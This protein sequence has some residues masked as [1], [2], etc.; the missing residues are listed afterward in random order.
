MN[1]EIAVPGGSFGVF[2][3]EG[4]QAGLPEVGLEDLASFAVVDLGQLEA[5][6]ELSGREELVLL[7]LVDGQDVVSPWS[8]Q[9]HVGLGG[10]QGHGERHVLEHVHHLLRSNQRNVHNEVEHFVG[11]IV[12]VG[13][14]HGEDVASD[15]YRAHEF[16][17]MRGQ[18]Y[19]VEDAGQ[20]LG[21]D[22][23]GVESPQLGHGHSVGEDSDFFLNHGG[24]LLDFGELGSLVHGE[25]V[26][27]SLVVSEVQ[28]AVVGKDLL[29]L[30]GRGKQQFLVGRQLVGIVLNSSE[31]GFDSLYLFGFE[32]L[33]DP[34][35][36]RG[37]D[38]NGR[39]HRIEAFV[40]SMFI[41]QSI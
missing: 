31:V 21:G 38:S 10:G 37:S 4:P 8:R 19:E 6:L 35:D 5:V 11:S 20:G 40:S 22:L 30:Q 29:V 41:D 26:I 2:D 7:V 3:V 9:G 13:H 25:E 24:N 16:S 32:I 18:S 23:V 15:L 36:D 12:D 1:L 14:G 39:G 27:P 34:A 28:Q 33:E 17:F